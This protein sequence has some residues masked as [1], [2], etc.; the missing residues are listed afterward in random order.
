MKKYDEHID[1][2]QTGVSLSH[3][4]L[5]LPVTVQWIDS[6]DVSSGW[7]VLSSIQNILDQI[8]YKVLTYAW[9]IAETDEF[10]IV[11]SHLQNRG[12]GYD[13]LYAG[14]MFIPISTS[15][16]KLL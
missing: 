5:P 14:V 16:I 9:L 13:V 10:Y 4:D 15:K 1:E 6:F 3:L 7:H 12:V 11:A 8:E 2:F